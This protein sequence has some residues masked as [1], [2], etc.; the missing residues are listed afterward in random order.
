M[1]NYHYMPE[2]EKKIK[3]FLED[4]KMLVADSRRQ[5]IYDEVMKLS[6][7]DRVKLSTYPTEE[8]DWFK[9]YG[10]AQSKKE[11]KGYTLKW[12]AGL[13]QDEKSFYQRTCILKEQIL[14]EVKPSYRQVEF[15]CEVTLDNALDWYHSC[16]E[17]LR[18]KIELVDPRTATRD[19]NEAAWDEVAFD[20]GDRPKVQYT[21]SDGVT[22]PRG[23]LQIA[24]YQRWCVL[25]QQEML[26]PQIV[27]LAPGIQRE[28][29][30]LAA[31]LGLTS[32]GHGLPNQADGLDDTQAATVR[33]LQEQGQTPLEFLVE[34]YKDPEAKLSDRINAASKLM[35]YVHR[36]VPV[37]TELETKDVSAPKL[38]PDQLR[39]LSPADRANLE[40]ILAGIAS[41]PAPKK[42]G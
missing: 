4:W 18:N 21:T 34:T 32:A 30:A 22:E 9:P 5:A 27:K 11:V 10:A 8:S 42:S 14:G 25:Y 38:A 13:T 7:E 39:G 20:L 40:R 31:A 15:F 19:M 2:H 23:Y 33:W 41:P 17:H 3:L 24:V 37:K 1:I 35:D 16:P 6:R 29:K 26:K 36:K 12:W 28:R